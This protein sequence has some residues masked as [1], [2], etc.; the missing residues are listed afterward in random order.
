MQQT[1]LI[2][3]I[4]PAHTPAAA[5]AADVSHPSLATTE[6]SATVKSTSPSIPPPPF[7]PN[8]P[9]QHS[10][11]MDTA[12]P[13]IHPTTAAAI[14]DVMPCTPTT[15]AAPLPPCCCSE[16][17]N[18]RMSDTCEDVALKKERMCRP[19]Q[20]PHIHSQTHTGE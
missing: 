13:A 6:L 4:A 1:T 16:S 18:N 17:D 19:E 3:T 9:T 14:V 8:S 20:R 15:A 7:S 10:R 5:A 12:T 2:H 11:A